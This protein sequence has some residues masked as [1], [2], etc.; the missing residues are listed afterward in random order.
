MRRAALTALTATALFW[1]ATPAPSQPPTKAGQPPAVVSPEVR[2][3]RTV[4]VRLHA[5]KAGDVAL[6]GEL[7]RKPMTKDDRGVWSVTVGPL[8]PDQYSY[9]FTVDGATVVDP[10]N[11]KLKIGRGSFVNLV[12][13]PGNPAQDLRPVPHGTLHV[14]RY[15]SKALGGKSRGLVVYTP[16]GYETATDR[17]YP[18]LY[19]LHGSGDDEHGWT[20]VGLA[21]RILDN[22][23][24][25]GKAVPMLVVMPDG[26]AAERSANTQ[27]FEADLLGDIIPLV[28]KT[29]RVRPG[30]ENRAIAGLS[31]GGG[32]SWVIGMGHTDLF[33][34]VCPFSMGGGNA[35]AVLSKLDPAETNKRLK[36]LWIGC[37]RQ[38]RLFGGSERLC[39]ELKAKGIHHTWHPSEGAHTWMVWRKYLAD[40]M[41]QL[42]KS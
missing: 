39:E 13:V 14:H 1:A 19:L 40:V 31:M 2:P 23:L 36:L 11:T 3:D 32:Q 34:Y 24:A 20:D 38:D 37:G 17:H 9:S 10:R 27:A 28:E 6:S 8:E 12:E 16:P 4:I 30:A 15:E 26:H 5:P 21:H 42:F 25:D 29:Y 18:V 7:G 41:P 35:P 22:L 33:A